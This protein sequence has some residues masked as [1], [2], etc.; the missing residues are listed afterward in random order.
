MKDKTKIELV[1]DEKYILA[2]GPFYDIRTKATSWVDIKDKKL[3]IL[4]KNNKLKTITFKEKIGAAV[5]LSRSFGYLI[6]G[7]KALY[8]Y[9]N[10]EI[11]VLKELNDIMNSGMRCND[12]KADK[13][14]RLWFSTI[15]DDGFHA[16]SSAL[17]CYT[18]REIICMQDGLKL[19]NGMAWNKDNTKFFFADSEEH[20]VY[21][22]DFDLDTGYI[23]NRKVLFE[24]KDGVP[25]GMT[26]D[27]NDNLYVCIWGGSRIEVRSSKTGI[28]KREIKLPTK[29]ITSCTFKGD[30]FNE[31][32]VTTASLEESDKYAGKLFK[33]SLDAKG[34]EPC[35][36][37]IE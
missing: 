17:Y 16:P 28:L 13:F 33:I 29:L 8:I 36:V 23:S 22:Y 19:G 6:C 9:E 31:L 20:V 21:S 27:D 25:D 7:E 34:K 3:F 12:A 26:I 4:D 37:K 11:K 32:F 10:N 5:P 1:N 24:I 30:N 18:N 35:L 15:V 2:E 14:G